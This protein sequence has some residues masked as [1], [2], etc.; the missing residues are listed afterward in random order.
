MTEPI[1]PIP[2]PEDHEGDYNP[3]GSWVFWYLIPNRSGNASEWSVH[4]HPLHSFDSIEDFLR[5]L[6]SVEHPSKLMRGCR[7][8]VFRSFAKPLWEDETVSN[9]HIVSVEIEKDQIQ[10]N[11]IATK[12]IDLVQDVLE[13]NSALNLSIL[14][15]EY[16]SKPF[17]WKINIWVSRTFENLEEVRT[18]MET[19]T[20]INPARISE[21]LQNED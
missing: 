4:L 11:E 19:I 6:N 5:L 16:Y 14:G 3:S 1:V 12:W 13:D 20:G 2:P 21:I 10:P 18:K 7:Y 9:G 17:S 8:Y 15:V